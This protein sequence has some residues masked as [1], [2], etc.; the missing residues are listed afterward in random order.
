MFDSGDIVDADITNKLQTE[1]SSNF[2]MQKTSEIINSYS[3][4]DNHNYLTS[5]NDV[6]KNNNGNIISFI[7]YYGIIKFYYGVNVKEYF[8][9]TLNLI[10]SSSKKNINTS[11]KNLI[12]SI[13]DKIA[14]VLSARAEQQQAVKNTLNH[15]EV[16]I[17]K[18]IKYNE[19]KI[20]EI[21]ND[22]LTKKELR[23]KDAR[24]LI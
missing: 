21:S 3:L 2:L 24:A 8:Q 15:N 12:E 1:E 4:F 22:T 14:N 16:A 9:N 18:F 17:K 6:N 13:S 23:K 11:I 19:K 5:R 7:C 10:D 20:K